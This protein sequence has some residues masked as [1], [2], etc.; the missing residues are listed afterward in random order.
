ME[1][2]FIQEGEKADSSVSLSLLPFRDGLLYSMIN[3]IDGMNIK[4]GMIIAPDSR[5]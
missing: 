5:G 2:T 1:F 3:R 4:T